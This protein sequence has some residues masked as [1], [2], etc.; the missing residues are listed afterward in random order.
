MKK[1]VAAKQ[2]G[3]GA[4]MSMVGPGADQRLRDK[5][6]GC[7]VGLAVGDA[8]GAPAEFLSAAEVA[9][10]YGRLED[11]LGD[12]HWPAGQHTD[13]TEMALC[14]ARS[15]VEKRA[16]VL[17]DIAARFVHWMVTD[18]RGIG[19]QTRAVL[20]RV[21]A[22]EEP[23]AASLEV[24]ERSGRQA[25]G[26]GGVMRC[27]PIGL[28]A[29]RDRASLIE[30]SRLT[31][32]LTHPDPRCEWSC[33]AVNVAIAE[34]LRDSESVA[35]AVAEATAGQCP[36]VE[37]AVAEARAS[38]VQALG[39]DGWDQ[40]YTIVTTRIALAALFGGDPLEEALVA[41]ISRGGDADTNGAVAGALLGARDGY[42]AI[43][44]R[45]REGLR[46]HDQI[47]TL[48]DR[49]WEVAAG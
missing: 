44:A 25:A 40:G 49:L 48:A 18:G 7:L 28:F 8:L 17:A 26:N 32:R 39:V 34:L 12:A 6:R 36:E 30:H 27:A 24:W 41:V 23:L 10:R 35:E 1:L 47:V 13:D 29:W 11:Y 14:L 4:E 5:F 15:L 2:A 37:A 20:T 42:Q 31:C 21:A 38:Q 19:N 45:W 3:P 33:V 46:A 16:V 9:A 22:G 43:P